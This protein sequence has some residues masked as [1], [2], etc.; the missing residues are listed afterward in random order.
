V[1]PGRTTAPTR[2][3]AGLDVPLRQATVPVVYDARMFGLRP[4][5]L[6]ALALFAVVFGI[7]WARDL[8]RRR[9]APAAPG[10]APR[11]FPT[12]SQ[13]A[14]GLVTNF[15]DFL[16]VGSY[17]TSTSIY[18]LLRMVPDREIPGTLLVGHMWP[19]V[20]QAIISITIIQVDPATLALLIAASIIG[21]WFGAGVVSR[22][23]RRNVQI[24]MGLALLAASGL[25]VAKATGFLPS[26]G[27]GIGLAGGSLA[28]GL[29]GNLVLGAL[30][31]LGIGAYGPSL[32]MFGLLGMD[33]KSIY[34][35]MMGSCAFIMPTS[36]V[37]FISRG[38]YHARAALG[39]AIGG[40][41][42]VLLAAYVIRSLPVKYLL[43]LV[44]FVAAYSA[45]AMLRSARNE[46]ANKT[47]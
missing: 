45:V 46:R 31:N 13:I 5:L 44:V 15:F 16:G 38:N 9:R 32:I 19:T 47:S 26:G 41:P 36:G 43:W 34:P 37:R 21:S 3:T 17:A 29:V 1:R 35:V 7:V 42:G 27:E 6:L 28:V 40:V 11:L 8:L 12:P 2:G 23:P 4:L 39:L 20:A 10:V 25:F 14:V 30:M 33:L 22:W 18:K 24:G